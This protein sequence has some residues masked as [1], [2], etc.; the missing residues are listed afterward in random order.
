MR[1]ILRDR[2]L[3]LASLGFL[4][5]AVLGLGIAGFLATRFEGEIMGLEDLSQDAPQSS[6]TQTDGFATPI[7]ER[8]VRDYQGVTYAA[9]AGGFVLLFLSL[10]GIAVYGQ[11]TAGR[12]RNSLWKRNSELL[13]SIDQLK[14]NQERLD[15]VLNSAGEGICS[16]DS[17]GRITFANQAVTRMT[18]WK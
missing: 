2:V 11:R 1:Q 13:S 15:Q 10:T 9:I 18:G 17:E 4:I 12:E 5:T 8:L 14:N 6:Q 3:R 16:L 7:L